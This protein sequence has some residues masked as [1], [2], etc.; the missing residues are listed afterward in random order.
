M[1]ASYR[2]ARRGAKR[3]AAGLQRFTNGRVAHTVLLQ[4]GSR[5]ASSLRASPLNS[6]APRPYNGRLSLAAAV[7][8]GPEEATTTTLRHVTQG[9]VHENPGRHC[10]R[11]A[12]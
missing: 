3:R 6:S 9:E 12:A 2:E 4:T 11:H 1:G 5:I 10:R 8:T 7:R